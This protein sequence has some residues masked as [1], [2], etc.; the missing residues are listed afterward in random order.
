M[1][2]KELT[3]LM[4]KPAMVDDHP[5]THPQKHHHDEEKQQS[6]SM[7]EVVQIISNAFIMFQS[8]ENVDASEKKQSMLVLTIYQHQPTLHLS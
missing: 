2:S 4:G 3:I 8:I 7:D 1:T 6:V 5:P